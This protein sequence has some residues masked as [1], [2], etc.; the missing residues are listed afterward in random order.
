M[1]IQMFSFLVACDIDIL[2]IYQIYYFCQFLDQL[3]IKPGLLI[4]VYC[5]KDKNI[6]TYVGCKLLSL[7]KLGR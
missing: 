7:I 5:I 3:E 4:Y 2:N 6:K 1:I